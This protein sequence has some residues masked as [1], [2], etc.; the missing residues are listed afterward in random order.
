MLFHLHCDLW[1][2]DL[3]ARFERPEDQAAAELEPG[4]H[5]GSRDCCDSGVLNSRI[6]YLRAIR[7]QIEKS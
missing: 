6:E 2:N 1:P 7:S 5:S 4:R 3:I